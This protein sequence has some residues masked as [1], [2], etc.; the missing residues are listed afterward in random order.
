M[1]NFTIFEGASLPPQLRAQVESELEPGETIAWID[2]PIP[3]RL[4]RRT[5]PI[6][7][8]AI[9]W[10]GF[11]I[12]WTTMAAWG[13]HSA[14][15][16]VGIF[17]CFPLFGVPFI[18]VGFGMLSSP[19]WAYRRARRTVYVLTERRA[20]IFAAGWR[21]S[22]TARSFEPRMLADIRRKQYAD[23]S[24]DIIFAQD[25]QYSSQGR[26]NSTDVGFLGVRDAR[27]AEQMLRALVQAYERP[28]TK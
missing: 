4:A 22:I 5:L 1:D 15:Q 8:F 19:Y 14:Q 20:I 3:G 11:A 10:T 9:P 27:A 23:G 28:A 2:Q 16:G 12:F 6:M 13:T 21:G 17:S 25:L 26:P 24:G 18:L 7:L